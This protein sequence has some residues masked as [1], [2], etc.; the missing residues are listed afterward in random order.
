MK[1][2]QLVITTPERVFFN[3]AVES[4]VVHGREGELGILPGH[5]HLLA[6]LLPGKIRLHKNKVME[7]IILSGGIMEVRPQK[8]E[9][10]ATAAELWLDIPDKDLR[11]RA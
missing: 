3:E 9:I 1:S 2:I 4:L 7:Y 5:G 10:F 6:E 11:R 8:V